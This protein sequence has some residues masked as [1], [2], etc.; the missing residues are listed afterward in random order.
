MSAD[1]MV[2]SV[3]D[4]MSWQSP[5]HSLL[6]LKQ[7]SSRQRPA[8][9]DLPGY[10]Q[11]PPDSLSEDDLNYLRMKGALTIPVT[12]V[13]NHLIQNFVEYVYGYLPIIDLGTFLEIIHGNGQN[14]QISLLLFQ[15]I[16]F[17]GAAFATVDDLQATGYQNRMQARQDLFQKAR[18]SIHHRPHARTYPLRPIQLLYDFDFEHAKVPLLQSTLLL[19]YWFSRG[20]KDIHYWMGAAVTIAHTSALYHLPENERA[21][22]AQNRLNRRIWWSMFN[23]DQQIAIGTRR[24]ARMQIEDHCVPMLTLADFE[25]HAVPSQIDLLSPTC[26][27]ARDTTQQR[28]LA[29]MCI[30]QCKLSVCISKILSSQ[31]T[32][33]SNFAPG[34]QSVAS[35]LTPKKDCL[36]DIQNHPCQHEL[37]QW[38]ANLPMVCRY[39][40]VSTLHGYDS[41]I[42]I[43]HKAVLKMMYLT[44]V[45]VLHHPNL[46]PLIPYSTSTSPLP[47]TAETFQ[48]VTLSQIRRAAAEIS[49]IGHELKRL[50]LI[51][52][53]PPTTISSL[54]PA[55]IVHLMDIKFRKNPTSTLVSQQ[56][57]ECAMI[58]RRLM[59]SY[60]SAEQA[61]NFLDDTRRVAN[62]RLDGID[63]ILDPSGTRGLR[64][65]SIFLDSHISSTFTGQRERDIDEETI[66]E[67]HD[68]NQMSLDMFPMNPSPE[69]TND[70]DSTRSLT[71]L[72]DSPLLMPDFFLE[73]LEEL[74]GHGVDTLFSCE[75]WPGI[76]QICDEQTA[77]SLS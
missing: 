43:V 58:L 39:D 71:G 11:S 51:H 44:A 15:A 7:S 40:S 19:T 10:I 2:R 20:Q 45:V 24:P 61:M 17:V 6:K 13:R 52:H 35:M 73:T 75:S 53:L 60:I 33:T 77:D 70:F 23:R 18:V 22:D 36:L 14:G 29:A 41:S 49:M 59:D 34:S 38:I 50:D 74:G 57:S 32:V 30:E 47:E 28:Q 26:I 67:G 42:M 12:S 27:L 56:Y 31:F 4:A 9:T 46:M 68:A 63:T 37:D 76:W 21:T 66:L 69:H 55:M 72:Q 8:D 25:F 1:E 65:G 16:M 5:P 64:G 62:I 48:E 54:V 3:P